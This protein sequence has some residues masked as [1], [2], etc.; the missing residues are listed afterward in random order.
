MAKYPKFHIH[1]RELE[2]GRGWKER[3]KRKGEGDESE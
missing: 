2:E 1:G 3:G